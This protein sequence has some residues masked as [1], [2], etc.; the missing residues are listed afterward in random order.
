MDAQFQKCPRKCGGCLYPIGETAGG[1]L[2]KC[3]VCES[4]VS[5]PK[6]EGA[7]AQFAVSRVVPPDS[8]DTGTS[9]EQSRVLVYPEPKPKPKRALQS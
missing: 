4:Q 1:N 2:F 6:L 3:F 9:K 7:D 8:R 5:Q